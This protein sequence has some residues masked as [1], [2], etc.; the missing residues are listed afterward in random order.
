MKHRMCIYTS[1]IYTEQFAMFYL[2][3]ELT[4]YTIS[5]VTTSYSLYFP[6][7][8]MFFIQPNTNTLFSTVLKIGHVVILEIMF[9]SPYIIIQKQTT[10]NHTYN[11]DTL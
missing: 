9:F 6:S 8:S 4:T 2:H 5:D 11:S 10:F 3:E 1:T 7:E